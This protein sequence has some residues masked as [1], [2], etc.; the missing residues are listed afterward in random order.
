MGEMQHG[1]ME[2]VGYDMYCRLLDEVV[3]EIKGEEIIEEIDVQ[4][5]LNVSS[6]IPDEFI[7]DSSQKIEL[8]QDI[9]LCKTEED[10]QNVKDGIIDRF[11]IYSKWNRKSFRDISNKKYG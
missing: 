10:I 5:D 8:Y 6:Y 4:I 9:A 2:Q 3:K 7:S 11:R 1:H